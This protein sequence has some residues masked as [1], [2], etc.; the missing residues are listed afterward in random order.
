MLIPHPSSCADYWIG[1]VLDNNERRALQY[2][3]L[4]YSQYHESFLDNAKAIVAQDDARD[5]N[6][7][8]AA[9]SSTNS[10]ARETGDSATSTPP[11]SSP[12][13]PP[14]EAG[15]SIKTG[16]LKNE[17]LLKTGDSASSKPTV[18]GSAGKL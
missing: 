13:S 14:K 11:Q 6:E 10:P 7:S 17:A 12:Q 4:F 2:I 18:G 1:T 5:Q 16:D 15:V 8:E 3:V 9:S